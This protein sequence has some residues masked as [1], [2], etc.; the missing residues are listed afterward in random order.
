L[1]CN[2]HIFPLIRKIAYPFTPSFG[3]MN[4][5]EQINL[6]GRCRSWLGCYCIW[7]CGFIICPDLY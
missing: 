6:G 7:F 1:P 2:G 4:Q 3:S 5:E